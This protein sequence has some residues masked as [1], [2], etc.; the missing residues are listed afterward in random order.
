MVGGCDGRFRIKNTPARGIVKAW[1]PIHVE[2][3]I[4]WRPVAA[5]ASALWA[6]SSGVFRIEVDR[7]G[8]TAEAP[9]TLNRDL[10]RVTFTLRNR[11]GDRRVELKPNASADWQRCR[12]FS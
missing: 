3:I 5:R 11:T 7:D 6:T 1:A 10:R 12:S 2:C 4:V 9:I 8:F